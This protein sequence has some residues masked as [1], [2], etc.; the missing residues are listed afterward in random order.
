MAHRV[1]LTDTVA[2]RVRGLQREGAI[3]V[4][5]RLVYEGAAATARKAVHEVAQA[6][7]RVE[8]AVWWQVKGHIEHELVDRDE[9]FSYPNGTY[10]P[11]DPCDPFGS[12]LAQFL[13]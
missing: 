9:L 5:W 4:L 1:N 11:Y 6:R 3:S 13:P 12:D 7:G 2:T 8:D 10:Y